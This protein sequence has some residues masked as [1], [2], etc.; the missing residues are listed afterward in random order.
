[1]PVIRWRK[2][3]QLKCDSVTSAMLMFWPLE[4]VPTTTPLLLIATDWSCPAANPFWEMPLMVAVPPVLANCVRL[5]LPR[6]SEIFPSDT[7]LTLTLGS[8]SVL[9][10]GL[11][12]VP[13]GEKVK[14]VPTLTQAG[15]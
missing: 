10:D 8:V 9:P 5:P 7:L 15:S 2:L 6:L 11:V 3:V 14:F 4:N 1:M 13:L 12:S